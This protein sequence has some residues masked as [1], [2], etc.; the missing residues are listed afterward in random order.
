MAAGRGT[1][2]VR[3]TGSTL[4]RAVDL[5]LRDLIN[6]LGKAG[7]YP[8]GHRFIAESAANLIERLDEAMAERDSITIGI[9]PRGLLVDGTAVDP[10]PGVMRDFAARLHRKN[11]GT[12]YLR[13]GVN[14]DDIA[15]LLSAVSAADADET[16]GRD[17][18]RLEHLRVEPMVYDVLALADPLNDRELDDVFWMSLVEAAFGRRLAEGDALPTPSQIAEAISERAAQGADGA[19]RVYEALASFSSAIAARGER[20]A[21]SARRRFV[22]VLSAL[23]RPTTTRVV[24]AAP[25]TASRRRFLRETLQLVPPA[26][27]LQLLES[28]AEADGEPISPQLRWLLGKLAGDDASAGTRSDVAP[29]AFTTEVLGLVE[30]W[31]GAIVDVDED[32]D[33]RLGLKPGRVVVLGLDLALASPAV[34]HAAR[35]QAAAEPLLDLLQILDNPDND[36]TVAAAISA[37]VLEPDLLAKLLAEPVP[38]FPLIE[39]VVQHVGVAATSPL[40]AAL[41]TAEERSARRRFLDMLVRI[42]PGAEPELLRELPGAPWYLARNILAVLAQLPSLVNADPVFAALDDAEPRVRQEALRVLVR[43]P[44]TRDRAVTQALE[45]GDEA[46]ARIALTALGG[47]CPPRLVAPV[48]TILGHATTD[49]Q[50]VAIRSLANTTN[51]L[52]VPHLLALVRARR[53]LFRRQRL[54]PKSPV[55]LAALEVLARRWSNH[56]PVLTTMQLAR[57]SNDADIVHALEGGA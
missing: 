8:A 15:M 36:P 7:M 29:A 2:S 46:M 43:H 45:S 51:P 9:L 21:G 3:Q 37:A 14:P 1:M 42:G 47:S 18:L 30:Q 24:A 17:G 28:V 34:I 32:V 6:A 35:Q 19:R 41:G 10:L 56:R 27:L 25:S 44:S 49:V 26:L 4:S 5:V 12:I 57:A 31:D 23:S 39:R 11:I 54:L 20:A 38:D 16:V 13:R 52:T 33:P 48:L 40:L 22:E 55:M 53:G 50:L